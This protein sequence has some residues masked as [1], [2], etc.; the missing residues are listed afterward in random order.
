MLKGLFF[1]TLLTAG[2]SASVIRQEIISEVQSCDVEPQG[3][4]NDLN[5]V[6]LLDIARTGLIP[7]EVEEGLLAARESRSC[8]AKR[9]IG[10]LTCTLAVQSAHV[11]SMCSS[12]MRR[13]KLILKVAN[14]LIHVPE[15]SSNSHHALRRHSLPS[16][17]EPS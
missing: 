3:L 16:S 12:K 9:Y 14:A 10:M 2:A 6:P 11:S 5:I 15:P 7:P 13:P 4:L 17:P 8:H 1:G